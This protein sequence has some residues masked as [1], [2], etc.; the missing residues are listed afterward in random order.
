MSAVTAGRRLAVLGSP[1]AHSK[2][3]LLHAAAYR[4][5]G[6]D[7]SYDR[8]EVDEHELAG[9]VG[10]LD[11]SWRG[12]SLT[13]PLKEAIRPLL[14]EVDEV[15]SVTGAVNTV[16]LDGARK[17]WNTDVPGIVRAF[18]RRGIAGLSQ[19]VLLGT[20]AT[21]RSA[22]VALHRMGVEGVSVVGRSPER[23]AATAGFAEQVGLRADIHPA[24]LALT[25]WPTAADLV[26][27]TL[28]GGAITTAPVPRP[29]VALFDVAYAESPFP[30]LWRTGAPDAVV[31][32]GLD[33]L[34]EQAL[35]QVR[36]FVGG[37]VDIALPDEDRVLAAMD[38]A[39]GRIPPAV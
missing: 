5:L 35:F 31:V 28:P 11:G 8:H 39:V 6:L 27:S 14:D 34:V 25:E 32:S 37:D 12:L 4:E 22:L 1:V 3:P 26:V 23:A 19:A 21:A 18:E 7:W 20:G 36:A 33:M 15:A 16:L 17:G 2:S 38:A 13:M 9:F 29:G 30:A 24:G 10:G